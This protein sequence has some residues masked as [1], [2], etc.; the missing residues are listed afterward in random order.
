METPE[1]L[2]WSRIDVIGPD[3]IEVLGRLDA[4]SA[5]DT[6]DGRGGAP[7]VRPQAGHRFAPSTEHCGSSRSIGL[8]SQ[9]A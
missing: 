8:R 3:G 2:L 6:G 4:Y 1:V 9:G 5:A 7:R